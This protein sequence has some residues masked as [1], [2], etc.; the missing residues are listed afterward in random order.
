MKKMFAAFCI[1]LLVCLNAIAEERVPKSDFSFEHCGPYALNAMRSAMEDVNGILNRFVPQGNQLRN[2]SVTKNILSFR[3]V[4]NF[5]ISATVKGAA[6][7]E[8]SNASC[9]RSSEAA[10]RLYFDLKDSDQVVV[11]QLSAFIINICVDESGLD[12]LKVSGHTS[13]VKADSYVRIIGAPMIEGL[14]EQM[15]GIVRAIQEQ[16]ISVSHAVN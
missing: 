2:I 16:L 9:S 11:D 15:P 4:K 5:A 13:V 12:H 7:L 3:F 14:A 1:S 6:I 8:R 10:F